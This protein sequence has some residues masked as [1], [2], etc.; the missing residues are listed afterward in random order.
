MIEKIWRS[1]RASGVI[2]CL[3][4]ALAI[5]SYA[6]AWRAV[7]ICLREV[8]T[9]GHARFELDRRLAAVLGSLPGQSTILAYTGAHSGAFQLARV[10][11]RRT[12]NEGTFVMWDASLQ[13]PAAAADYVVASDEDPVATAVAAHSERLTAVATIE[14]DGQPRTV[15]YQSAH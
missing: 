12:I 3:V 11:M 9:N 10:P 6:N 13:H 8:R 15:I 14:V 5:A 2:A 4:L 7:P 1:Q